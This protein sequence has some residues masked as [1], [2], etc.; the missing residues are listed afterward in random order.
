MLFAGLARAD[1]RLPHI[2]ADH[3]VLQRNVKVPV[4]GWADPGER[5]TV[6]FTGRRVSVSADRTAN[7]W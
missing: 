4:W 5:V 6:E 7:G 2:F 3:M 1:V